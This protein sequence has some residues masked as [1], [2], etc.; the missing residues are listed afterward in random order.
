MRLVKEQIPWNKG[1]KTGLV[2]K[3][4]FK[5]EHIAWN[6]GNHVYTGGKKFEKGMVPWN[7]QKAVLKKCLTCGREFTSNPARMKRSE[8]KYCSFECYAPIL[9]K[10]VGEEIIELPTR[11]EKN[12]IDLIQKHNLPYKYVG[13]GDFWIG[14]KNPDFVNVNGEKKLIEVGCEYYKKRTD[15]SVKNYIKNR[16]NHFAQY[17][18]KTKFLIRDNPTEQEIL[19]CFN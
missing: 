6:K 13:N 4:A 7:K 15:G 10:R 8:T 18:W 2:P 14:G 1:K 12:V 9:L 5:K 19:N 16:K 11:L 3:S 17:G